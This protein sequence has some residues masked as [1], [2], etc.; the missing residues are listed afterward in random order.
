MH[1]QFFFRIVL[2][3][4]I[5]S[6][7]IVMIH[8]SDLCCL[9]KFYL[10]SPYAKTVSRGGKYQKGHSKKSELLR[11][12]DEVTFKTLLRVSRVEKKKRKKAFDL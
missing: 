2:N 11:T 12:P 8:Q 7:T 5:A 3:M 10:S 4:H 6:E 9:L 1:P